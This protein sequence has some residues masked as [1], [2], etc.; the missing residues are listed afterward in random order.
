ME[1]LLEREIR[2]S[3]VNCS[4]GEATRA[5][6]P[7]DLAERPWDDLDF[8]GWVD[9]KAPQTGYLV[10]PGDAG[11]VGI[12]LRRNQGG[13][14]RARMCSLCLTTHSGTGVSLMVAKRAGRAGRDGNSVGLDICSGLECSLYARGVLAAPAV[15]AA[16]ETL[17]AEARVARLRRNLAAF[18]GRVTR[19]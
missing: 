16:H 3:F 9:P 1:S 8:L 10:A 4:R 18:L 6:L 13:A 12:V 15:A 14:G 2:A 11:P 5:H 17:P 7:E 19:S